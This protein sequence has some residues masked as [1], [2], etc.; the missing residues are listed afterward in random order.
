MSELV[1]FLLDRIAEDEAA[2]FGNKPDGYKL[3]VVNGVTGTAVGGARLRA[4]CE[5][6]RW[7]VTN[8]DRLLRSFAE[9]GVFWNDVNRRERSH[10]NTTLSLLAVA[11]ADHADYRAEW[12]P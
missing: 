7:I 2:A 11:Y 4:E 5:A 10:A 1:E 6:K 12:R 3:A 8:A 9:P